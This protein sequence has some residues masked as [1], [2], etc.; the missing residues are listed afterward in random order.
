MMNLHTTLR[1]ILPPAALALLLG[2]LSCIQMDYT[3]GSGYL[4]TDQQFDT[5]I[6]EFPLEDIR[7]CPA[8]S[9]SGYSQT[10]ITFGAIR[11][12]DFGLTTHRSAITLV[13]MDDSLDFGKDPSFRYFYVMMVADSV[14]VIRAL[15]LG[16]LQFSDIFRVIWKEFRVSFLCGATLSVANYV[17][18]MLL[19]KVTV[20]E[21]V[22]ICVTMLSTVVIA[23]FVGCTL[24]M[25]AKKANLDPAV[26]ASPFITTIVDVLSLLIYFNIATLI[27]GIV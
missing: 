7:L 9:L 19:E 3:L 20:L 26:M 4:A 22:T 17:R 23:K 15:S 27:L 1:R 13:P 16:E 24:P 14:S 5:F 6:A 12:K 10:R 11:D 21:A 2:C 25:L 8:D 18:L